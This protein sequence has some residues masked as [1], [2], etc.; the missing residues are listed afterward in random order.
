VP[1]RVQQALRGEGGPYLPYL[2]LVR[3]IE[4]ASLFDIRE[5]AERL[6]LSPLDVNA[7]LLRALRA[8][9]HLD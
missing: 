5:C 4:N 8:A 2:D 6:F 1:D 3:A 9:R 7:A